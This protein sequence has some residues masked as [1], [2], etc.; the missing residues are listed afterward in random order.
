LKKKLFFR[1]NQCDQP[2][3]QL[4]DFGR[5]IDMTLFPPD[6]TFTHTVKTADFICHEM[7]EKLP[8][9]YQVIIYLNFFFCNKLKY[10]YFIMYIC[11]FYYRL[12]ILDWLEL[13]TWFSCQTTWKLKKYV[14]YGCHWN[15]FQGKN[16]ILSF[17]FV[18]Q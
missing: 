18:S 12:I 10:I 7:R 3:V 5:S 4:I 11:L 16:N 14:N 6:T 8:W 2:C 9:T 1:P 13:C 15:H 17:K